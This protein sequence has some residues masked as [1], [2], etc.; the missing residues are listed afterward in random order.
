M[1]Y[2]AIINE[3]GLDWWRHLPA[4]RLLP[5]GGLGKPSDMIQS[6]Y[7][8]PGLLFYLCFSGRLVSASNFL[9]FCSNFVCDLTPSHPLGRGDHL[10]GSWLQRLH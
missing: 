8:I 7:A 2:A 10:A 4:L 6:I 9:A 1:P 5:H 3:I